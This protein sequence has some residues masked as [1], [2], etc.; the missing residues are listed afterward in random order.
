MKVEWFI[1]II[2]KI[3]LIKVINKS[4]TKS[5]RYPAHVK[6]IVPIAIAISISLAM[7]YINAFNTE[8]FFSLIKAFQ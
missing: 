8:S 1:V 5:K 2:E 3:K 6:I 7:Y 4:K